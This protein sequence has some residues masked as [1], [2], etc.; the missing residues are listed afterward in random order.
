MLLFLTAGCAR[1][2]EHTPP[3][4]TPTPARFKAIDEQMLADQPAETQATFR[5][6][7]GDTADEEWNAAHN[8]AVM[9]DLDTKA[10]LRASPN[11]VVTRAWAG[12]T[13][14]SFSTGSGVVG[15]VLVSINGGPEKPFALASGGSQDADWIWRGSTYQFRLYA[16]THQEHLLR[17]LTVT[18]ANDVATTLGPWPAGG[19]LLL[20][21]AALV[22][23]WTRRPVAAHALEVSFALVTTALV[24]SVV[25]QTPARAVQDQPFPDSAEYADAARHLIAGDGYITTVHNTQPQPPRY[26]PG[27]SVVLLPFAVAGNVPAAAV[28]SGVAY[29]LAAVAAAWLLGGPIPAGLTAALVGTAPFTIEAASLLMSDALVTA[30]MVLLAALLQARKV[31]A[32]VLLAG[33]LP[34]LRLSAGV[35][36][37]AVLLAVP[38]R[39]AR[40]RAPLVLPGLVALGVFQWATFGSPLHTGYDY[41][42]PNLKSFDLAY[43]VQR[44][45]G[46]TPT[47][48]GDALNGALLNWMC[49][50]PDDGG[51]LTQLPNGLFY[52]A[53][54][55]GPLWVLAPPLVGLVGLVYALRHWREP[56][57]RFSLSLTLLTL[58][59][60]SVYVFQ[61]A[62]LVAAPA[63]LLTI[64]ASVAAARLRWPWLRHRRR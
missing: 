61:A 57:A 1:P 26:P 51:P 48:V 18:R 52:P 62:R 60:M 2:A 24:L 41:W 33:A 5:A 22:A 49:P 25:V 16:G 28:W 30:L 6:A 44:V 7:H 58:A 21:G 34:L 53:V 10:V 43:A 11:P 54:L 45:M 8:T 14:I 27:F 31:G 37:P 15:Q 13:T 3:A 46:D 19:A 36:I 59:V 12:T 20:L 50:C 55:F 4:I 29:V 35:A 56:A 47:M 64:Q 42:L 17:T 23:R 38:S 9:A 40:H 63:V 39:A 32:A